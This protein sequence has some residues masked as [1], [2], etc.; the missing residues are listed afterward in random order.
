MQTFNNHKCDT[1]LSSS[2]IATA[3]VTF[4][5]DGY[6]QYSLLTNRRSRRQTVATPSTTTISSFQE[7]IFLRFRTEANSGL[8][9][10]LQGSG[11]SN[12]H[13]TLSVSRY[14]FVYTCIYIIY[15][16]T[17]PIHISYPN[18]SSE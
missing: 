16:W 14:I 17:Q 13:L 6:A 2:I 8:L 7:S 3:S 4:G 11:G 5:G 10:S 9:L 1:F 18:L 12:E 15:M